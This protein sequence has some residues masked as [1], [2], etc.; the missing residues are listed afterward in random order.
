[1]PYGPLRWFLVSPEFHHW[2]HSAE[3]EAYDKNFASLVA[4]WDVVFGTVHLPR[5]REPQHYGIEDRVPRSW[6]QRMIHPFRR[7]KRAS[8]PSQ[9]QQVAE[10][11]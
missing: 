4:S 6:P 2:H 5:G 8:S 7:S 9:D 3:R 11:A 1:M 10:S